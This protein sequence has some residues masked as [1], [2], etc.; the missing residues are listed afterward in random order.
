MVRL[1]PAQWGKVLYELTKDVKSNSKELDR[2]M[3]LF[4][5]ML[6]KNYVLKRIDAIIETY[7]AYAKKQ[8]G[9]KELVITTAR[10]LNSDEIKNIEKKFGEKVESTMVVDPSII[11]GVIVKTGNTILNGSIANQLE[12]LK[13]SL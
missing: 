8:E 2:A 7:E 9:I 11:G 5:D 3:T 1:T 13:H 4:G 12:Q 6:Q 10:K